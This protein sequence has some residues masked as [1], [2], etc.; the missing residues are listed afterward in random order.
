MP[1]NEETMNCSKARHYLDLM[2]DGELKEGLI[3]M[4]E[5]HLKGCPSCRSYYDAGKTLNQM[6]G[7]APE[8]AFPE[9]L[10]QRILHQAS[11]HEPQRI[12]FARR[13]KL[14]TIPA[15]LA[16][17]VSLYVGALMGVKAY[18]ANTQT[19]ATEATQST[20][21]YELASF[22]E[23]LLMDLDSNNGGYNE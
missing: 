3:P 22:G 13:W 19:Y 6:L 17:A 18:A 16:V 14:Q 20:E 23:S 7:M 9:W 2:L 8:A 21:S 15:L 4:A 10:H 12:G 1:A 11:Q 5:L